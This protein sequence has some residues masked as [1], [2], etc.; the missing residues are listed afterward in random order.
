MQSLKALAQST[1]GEIKDA[2]VDAVG[3]D[4]DEEDLRQNYVLEATRIPRPSPVDSER[5]AVPKGEESAK[6]ASASG[7]SEVDPCLHEQ[8]EALKEF[9]ALCQ[10]PS[11]EDTLQSLGASAEASQ[12]LTKLRGGPDLSVPQVEILCCKVLRQVLP[13]VALES[14]AQSGTSDTKR[15]LTSFNE[16]YENLLEE[17]MMLQRKCRDLTSK[18]VQ[19]EALAQQAEAWQSAHQA[20]IRR[21]EQLSSENAELKEQM[22]TWRRQGIETKER[23]QLHS[24]LSQKDAELRA[25]TDALRKLEEIMEEQNTL[26]E[27]NASLKRELRELR[28]LH[29]REA[30]EAQ[31][32]QAPSGSGTSGRPDSEN[33]QTELVTLQEY[34]QLSARCMAAEA[35]L[36]DTSAALEVLLQEKGRRLED[37]DFLVD[38]RLVASMLALYHEHLASGQRALAE[39]VLAQ[40]IHVLGGVPEEAQKNRAR[41]KAAAA[42]AEARLAEPLGN[43]FLDF[44]EKEATADSKLPVSLTGSRDSS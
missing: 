35:E 37:Q 20:A 44:L 14:I 2:L 7:D 16:R 27:Q 9:A 30:Q 26:S 3:D 39:Q 23:S 4:D 10:L 31:E 25:S 32:L 42:A 5:Q 18:N 29:V 24:L 1:L 40:A 33:S 22:A 36:K 12:A 43:A 41:V 11:L 38:R 19:F 6:S 15:L 13:Q 8:H 21:I 17:H 34:Q 28:E